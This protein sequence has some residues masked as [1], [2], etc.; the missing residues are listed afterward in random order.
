M[1]TT[2]G[3]I[4]G[5]QTSEYVAPEL[6]VTAVVAERGFQNSWPGGNAEPLSCDLKAEYGYESD[7]F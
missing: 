2:I 6:F 3:N 5:R 7:N 1:K 4:A